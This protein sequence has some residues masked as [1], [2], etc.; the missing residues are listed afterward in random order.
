MKN[1]FI[2]ISLSLLVVVCAFTGCKDE[3]GEKLLGPDSTVAPERV[4]DRSLVF[5]NT[6]DKQDLAAG[7]AVNTEPVDVIFSPLQPIGQTKEITTAIKLTNGKSYKNQTFKVSVLQEEALLTQYKEHNGYRVKFLPAEAYKVVS[8]LISV[9]QQGVLAVNHSMVRLINSNQMEINQDYLLA[10]KLE[11]EE[12]FVMAPENQVMYVHLKRKGGSGEM[13]GAADF[14]PMKGD[15]ILDAGGVDKGINRN[16]LYFETP[17]KSFANLS[18]CT[19]EGLIYVDAFKSEDERSDGTLAG[20]SSLWGY[21]EGGTDPDFLLRFGDAGVATNQ[22]QVVIKKKKYVIPFKFKEK[23]WYHIA[24]TCNGAN[25]KFYVNA[26]EKFSVEYTEKISLGG[27]KPFRLGQSFNQWRGFNG[28]MSE[29]RIWNKDRTPR[30]LKLNAL[31][32]VAL[33]EERSSLLAYWKMNS[34]KPDTNGQQMSD[35]S[36][37]GNDLSVLRQGASGGSLTPRVVIDNEIDINLN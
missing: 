18:K 13:E 28:K 5:M 7:S 19:I 12:G 24:M 26:K 1:R 31:D 8:D 35:A 30:E 22:L 21:E 2:T 32:V 17:G 9:E 10:L 36:G 33:A 4:T 6:T 11:S 15:N 14:R 20:I 27:T 23:K 3:F 25:I 34:V 29:V 37:R 16:N